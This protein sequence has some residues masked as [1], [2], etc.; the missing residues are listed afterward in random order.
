M[1]A[2]EAEYVALSSASK[3]VLRLRQILL[4]LGFPQT[5]PT[6]IYEDCKSTVA[7]AKSLEVNKKSAHIMSRICSSKRII[8]VQHIS[9]EFQRADFLGGRE[10]TVAQF[11]KQVIQFMTGLFDY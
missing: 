11:L 1:S 5:E 10:M 6:R 2:T 8:D 9:R 7:M 3:T 4:E